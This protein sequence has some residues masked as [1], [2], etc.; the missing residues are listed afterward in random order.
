VLRV[1]LRVISIVEYTVSRN[2]ICLWEKLW[3]CVDQ[4]ARKKCFSGGLPWFY[5]V[6]ICFSTCTDVFMHVGSRCKGEE[7]ER[8]A[9]RLRVATPRESFDS[10]L[11]MPQDFRCKFGPALPILSLDCLIWSD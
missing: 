5:L 8:E 9:S 11:T 6:S 2:S 3:V 1:L 4:T 7:A 10:I